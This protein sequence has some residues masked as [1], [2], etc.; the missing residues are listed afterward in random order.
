MINISGSKIMWAL[1]K[2]KLKRK[3]GFHKITRCTFIANIK[4]NNVDIIGYGFL[5][6]DVQPKKN[7]CAPMK[8]TD[9]PQFEIYSLKVKEEFKANG[10]AAKVINVMYIKVDFENETI[11]SDV[12]YIREDT[13]KADA[14]KL[15]I[16]F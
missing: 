11:E 10:L 15:K 7:E 5:K 4:E 13:G 12:F 14:A 2:P 3:L 1:A 16:K 9:F 6:D 8:L